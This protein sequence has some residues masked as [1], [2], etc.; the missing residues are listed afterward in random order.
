MKPE[1]MQCEAEK[2]ERLAVIEDF[3]PRTHRLRSRLCQEHARIARNGATAELR[4][5]RFEWKHGRGPD[6]RAV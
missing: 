5:R 6:A 1:E 3:D 4:M 2:C